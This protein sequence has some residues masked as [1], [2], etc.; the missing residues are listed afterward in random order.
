MNQT[1]E[2]PKR[3]LYKRENDEI[4][5]AKEARKQETIKSELVT[6]STLV[7]ERACM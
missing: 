4:D 7:K 5:I 2:F 6:L 1:E 3:S